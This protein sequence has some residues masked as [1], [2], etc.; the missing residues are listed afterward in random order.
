VTGLAGAAFKLRA[1]RTDSECMPLPDETPPPHVVITD[2][3]SPYELARCLDG[4]VRSVPAET[5][6]TVVSDRAS[7]LPPRLR[8][9]A[10]FHRPP[11]W[12]GVEGAVSTLLV[13]GRWVCAMTS[14]TTVKGPWLQAVMA[15]GRFDPSA[16][17]RLMVGSSGMLVFP[18]G[19]TDRGVRSD[20]WCVV[21]GVHVPAPG[22]R[23]PTRQSLSAVLIVKDEEEVLARCLQAVRPFVDE[24]VV[25]DTGSSDGT[26]SVARAHADVVVEG[27]WDDDFGAA[28]NRALAHAT[29]DWIF[30]VDADEVVEGD[31]ADLRALIDSSEHDQMFAAIFSPEF[32]GS[33]RGHENRPPRFFRRTRHHW[34]HALH[35]FPDV[36][37]GLSS[38]GVSPTLPPVRLVHSGYLV[39]VFE[40]RNKWERNAS[41]AA[42]DAAS[43]E[44]VSGRADLL[45]NQARSLTGAGRLEEALAVYS[46]LLT[47]P[48]SPMALI[49]A[50]RAG[51][52][53]HLSRGSIDEAERWVDLLESEQES[54]GAVAVLRAQ[55]ALARGDGAGALAA[56]TPLLQGAP[57]G[58]DV[59][60]IAFPQKSL[61]LMAAQV[62][63]HLGNHDEAMAAHRSVMLLAPADVDI[64]ETLAVADALR[65]PWETIAEEAPEEM[66]VT[67]LRHAAA[68]PPARALA[69]Y[70]ALCGA[71]P[72]DYRPVVAGNIIGAR[73]DWKTALS[74]SARAREHALEGVSGLRTLAQD[75]EQALT[76]RCI[77][78]ALQHEAFAD[79]AAPAA[80][81]ELA[82]LLD[83]WQRGRVDAVLTEL[84]LTPLAPSLTSA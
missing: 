67:S 36:L 70:E 50:G 59:W 48:G 13:E 45:S 78:W 1:A 71:R 25:Y 83:R 69:W 46:T 38:R 40:E 57:G 4:V 41:I 16:A 8:S 55:V 74:W 58:H 82:G 84:G 56:L 52:P 30:S 77:A 37:P 53:L 15:R 11:S 12:V 80:L 24:I 68:M 18:P 14:D 65:I 3:G 44:T 66:V 22:A 81:L 63:Q 60:G 9:R 73:T 79:P 27:Y 76:D 32:A 6:I 17:G 5:D 49:S 7:T 10:A 21:P 54:P 64:V 43:S 42:Q 39:E 34:R 33:T 61:H 26:A 75:P 51:V 31:V 35:E 20:R 28:R 23:R 47:T 62:H 29:G 2:T 72:Q 19:A